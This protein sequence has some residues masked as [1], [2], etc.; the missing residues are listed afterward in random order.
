[1]ANKSR[2]QA[3]QLRGGDPNQVLSIDNTGNV[4]WMSAAEHPEM[5]GEKGDGFTGGSFDGDTGTVTFTSDDGL[6]FTTGDLRGADGPEGPAG[7][8]GADGAEGPTGPAGSYAAPR[9]GSMVSTANLVY[10]TDSYDQFNLTGQEENLTISAPVGTPV[11]GQRF[12]LRITSDPVIR[13]IT[14]DPVFVTFGDG[15]PSQTVPNKTTYLGFIYNEA[16]DR[17]DV[18][19]STEEV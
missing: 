9:V 6:G 4:A 16:L 14:W 7:A 3:D 2:I 11:D 5:R 8:D 12:I 10:D 13:N 18:V 1:M 17:Y 15:R 19:A